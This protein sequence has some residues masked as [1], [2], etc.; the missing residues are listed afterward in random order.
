MGRGFSRDGVCFQGR[1]ASAMYANIEFASTITNLSSV[2]CGGS[3]DKVDLSHRSLFSTS[4][5]PE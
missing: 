3:L 1:F 2:T 5:F 4:F